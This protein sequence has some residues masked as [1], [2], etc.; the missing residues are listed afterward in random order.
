VNAALS[1]RARVTR[2]IAVTAALG[3]AVT[4]LG[5]VV[6]RNDVDRLNQRRVD[7]PATEAL[8]GVQQLTASVDQVLAT[9]N[10]VVAASGV[11]PERFVAVLGPDVPARRGIVPPG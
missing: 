10:G 1:L 5:Y 3:V 8:L 4:M 2:T 7:R 6:V 9:A 11:D